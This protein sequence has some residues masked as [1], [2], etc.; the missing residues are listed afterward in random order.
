MRALLIG[1][2]GYLGR[3]VVEALGRVRDLD[4]ALGHRSPGGPRDTHL[5]LLDPATF[6][7]MK[8]HDVVVNCADSVAAPPERMLAYALQNGVTLVDSNADPASLERILFMHRGASQ[9]RGGDLTGRAILGVGIFP[10]LSNLLAAGVCQRLQGPVERLE[11]GIRVTA[12]SGAGGGMVALMRQSLFNNCVVYEGGERVEVPPI[13]PAIPMRFVSGE[14][15]ALRVGLPETIMLHWSRGVPNVASYLSPYPTPLRAGLRLTGAIARSSPKAG[16]VLSSAMHR[17]LAPLRTSVLSERPSS[18]E[19]AVMANRV[20]VDRSVGPSA[21]LA[22]K[23]GVLTAAYA[24]AG[25]ISLVDGLRQGG[26]QP[27]VYLPDEA[28]KLPELIAAMK[29]VAPGGLDLTVQERD[30]H[31]VAAGAS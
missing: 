24:I 15:P 22:A 12:L 2:G 28:L 25:A 21:A 27:G 8:K 4:V 19:I 17:M 30:L 31:G 18:V 5:D 6:P 20:G 11:V 1:G 14:Y 16:R 23:E 29:A 9:R 26:L 7:V 3:K 10:G 13:G